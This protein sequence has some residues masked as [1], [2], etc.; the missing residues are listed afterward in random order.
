[1]TP[2]FYKIWMSPALKEVWFLS[3]PRTADGQIIDPRRFSK[4]VRYNGPSPV[5]VR[6]K[7]PGPAIDFHFGALDMLVVSGRIARI[8]AAI[9]PADVQRF[10]VLLDDRHCGYEI[11]NI[12]QLIPC[13]DES[14]SEFTKW[15][16][17]DNRPDL[18]G[19]YRSM[20]KLRLLPAACTGHAIFRVY[21]WEVAPIASQ[22]LKDALEEARCTGIAFVPVT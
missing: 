8:I 18:I 11:L 2:S 19:P 12:T 17:A 20:P 7:Y 6:V 14:R 3:E 21:G 15:V 1:M 16:E 4:G 22:Q 5:K 13:V 9:A 10:P